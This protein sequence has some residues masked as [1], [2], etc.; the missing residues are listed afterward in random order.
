VTKHRLPIIRLA[1]V[2]RI[3]RGETTTAEE[4]AKLQPPG[5]VE[6]IAEWLRHYDAEGRDAFMRRKRGDKKPRR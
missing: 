3:K 1:I 4:A 5:T 6:E 2:E